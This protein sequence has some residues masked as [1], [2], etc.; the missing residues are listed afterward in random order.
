VNKEIK[1]PL[2]KYYSYSQLSSYKNCPYQYKF[3]S[4]LKI[5]TGGNANF[6]FGNTMHLTLQRFFEL[7]MKSQN[8]VQVDLFK[9]EKT[10]T[11]IKDSLTLNML[12][13]IYEESWIDDW[14]NSKED[15][16][17]RRKKGK[18]ILKEFYNKHKGNWP[19]VI[20]LEQRFKLRLGTVNT[21]SGGIDRI[22]DDGEKE[23]EL[24]IIKQVRRSRLNKIT[25]DDKEQLL[26]YQMA[27]E[28]VLEKEGSEF[29]NFII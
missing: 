5:P 3:G 8:S 6:S 16:E 24:L 14:Y 21:I 29:A 26:I 25:I 10:Q 22:D 15:K 1:Y 23:Y 4:V 17:K 27:A 11:Q 7:I 2:P 28:D 13:K 18:E 12:L 19:K 9:K 20:S